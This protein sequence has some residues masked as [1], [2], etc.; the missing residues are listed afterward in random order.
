MRQN[1]EVILTMERVSFRYSPGTPFER[2]A[3]ID[4][5]LR[6]M[7]GERVAVVGQTGSGKSTLA[8]LCNGILKP[9]DG[10]V[11]VFGMDTRGDAKIQKQLR[12]KVGHVMQNPEDQLFEQYV[13]D[14]VA[15][16]PLKLG[17]TLD[18]ARERARSAM[19]A[20]GLDFTEKDT[21][22]YTLS[23]GRKRLVAI[24]GILAMEPELLILDEP[25][26]G[27]DPL[28][29]KSLLDSLSAMCEEKGT[30]LLLITHQLSE[31]LQLANRVIVMDHGKISRD[32]DP[33]AIFL[34]A[35]ELPFGLDV[36][37]E[38]IMAK[39]LQAAGVRIE[40]KDWNAEGFAAT[41]AN[42]LLNREVKDG[43]LTKLE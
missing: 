36:P 10:N 27:L 12:A 34:A 42:S 37:D 32:G 17:L 4:I 20:V 13:G 41:M 23:R 1:N 39:R 21:P 26:S 8:G 35:E 33:E 2:L 22:I 38:V 11:T 19:A 28:T 5:A 3:L 9:S 25:T 29:A 18:E 6:V 43:K 24:A 16:G 15:F 31:V 40:R 7:R 14:D 30:T